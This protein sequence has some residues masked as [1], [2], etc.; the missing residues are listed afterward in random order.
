MKDYT[1]ILTQKSRS[2]SAT[3]DCAREIT[4]RADSREEAE[5][6]ALA[7]QHRW[8]DSNIIDR[9]IRWAQDPIPQH[10]VA[11][12]LQFWGERDPPA[13][14]LKRWIVRRLGTGHLVDDDETQGYETGVIDAATEEDARRLYEED[15]DN[16]EWEEDENPGVDFSHYDDPEIEEQKLG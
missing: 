4:I 1:F 10:D 7:Q 9:T 12:R 11:P 2:A 16:V 13:P 5:A 3:F 6:K 8:S 15:S 14:G